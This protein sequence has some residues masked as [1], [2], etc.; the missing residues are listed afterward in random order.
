MAALEKKLSF[1]D[2]VLKDKE[3]SK[4][5]KKNEIEDC[6]ELKPF[7]RNVDKIFKRVFSK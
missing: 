3:I 1:K 5:L 4:Y 2:A 6:F 7:V